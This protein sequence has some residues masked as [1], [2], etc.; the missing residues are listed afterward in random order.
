M[1]SLKNIIINTLI[2][3]GL[4]LFS[5]N[6]HYNPYSLPLDLIKDINDRIFQ[7]INHVLR[8]K[9]LIQQKTQ[10]TMRSMPLTNDVFVNVYDQ[11]YQDSVKFS[12]NYIETRVFSLNRETHGL[13]AMIYERMRVQCHKCRIELK[14]ISFPN[15]C[16]FRCK[17]CNLPFC[18]TCSI[19][20]CI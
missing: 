19:H 12:D 6:S 8:K 3:D 17:D 10:Q 1:K 5:T 20:V 11:S 7:K 2:E 16:S 13:F 15:K 9:R 18:G 4:G 14:S